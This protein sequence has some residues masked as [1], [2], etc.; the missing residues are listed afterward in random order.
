MGRYV[1]SCRATCI[2]SKLFFCFFS[3]LLIDRLAERCTAGGDIL[4]GKAAADLFC[5]FVSL[6]FVQSGVKVVFVFDSCLDC[7]VK[8]V[9][10][11]VRLAQLGKGGVVGAQAVG[12]L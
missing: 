5:E 4:S 1:C 10:E 3:E 2:V 6:N 8:V 11:D 7:A 9:H 12:F